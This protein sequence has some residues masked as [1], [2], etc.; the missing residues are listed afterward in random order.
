MRLLKGVKMEV[1]GSRGRFERKLQREIHKK[2]KRQ[3]ERK[4][5]RKR[6]TGQTICKE[7]WFIRLA[8]P[9]WSGK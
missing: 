1:N 9:V 8:K 4:Y 2:K 5:C 6:E 7:V 3:R